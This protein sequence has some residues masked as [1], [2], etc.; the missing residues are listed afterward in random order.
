MQLVFLT[1]QVIKES[2]HPRKTAFATDDH[3]LMF[4]VEFHPRHVKRNFYLLGKALQFGVQRPVLRLSPGL[5]RTLSQSFP[6]VGN[7]QV[8]I[9]V[10]GVA[11]SLAARARAIG[12]V[13]REQPRLG[14]LVTDVTALALEAIREP[15]LS[16]G[17]SLLRRRLK[18]H[19]SGFAIAALNRIHDAGAGI[20]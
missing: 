12:I 13:E 16:G 10:D 18:D 19:L 9:E 20:S 14:L 4:L 2:A 8:E 1:L 11:E 5:N 6:F 15:D 3:A 17:F 7:D